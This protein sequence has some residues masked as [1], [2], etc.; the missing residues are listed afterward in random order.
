MSDH[1]IPGKSADLTET[2]GTIVQRVPV[3]GGH[4]LLIMAD[5]CI[6]FA[7]WCDRHLRLPNSDMDLRIAPALQFGSHRP[8]GTTG[9]TV[10]VTD[11]LGF[12]IIN[13]EPSILCDDCGT[14]GFVR[15]G[16]W[17]DA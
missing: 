9:H 1:D 4:E 3:G 15:N 10:T 16:K 2:Y 13:V 6:R 12:P 17:S 7:H 5:S 14:H 11:R 8:E